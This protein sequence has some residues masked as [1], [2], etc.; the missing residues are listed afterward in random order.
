[1]I[2]RV[3]LDLPLDASPHPLAE[4]LLRGRGLAAKK[5]LEVKDMRYVVSLVIGIVVWKVVIS[6]AVA[7]AVK[8]LETIA[9]ALGG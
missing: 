9:R 6:P 1:V 3:V 8:A 2:G 7:E 5:Q 4:L